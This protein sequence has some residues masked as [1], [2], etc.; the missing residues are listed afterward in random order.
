[1]SRSMTR[2]RRDLLL[3]AGLLGL[4]MLPLRSAFGATTP[5]PITFT[6]FRNGSLFGSHNLTFTNDGPRLIVDIEIAFDYKLAFIPLY[7]YRHQNREVWQDGRLIALSSETDDNG[8]AHKVS[9]TAE[10]DQLIV[11]GSDGRL[12]LP[13]DTPSTSYWNEA[14]I[15]RGEWL[16]TQRG[17]L[18]RSKVTPGKPEPLTIGDKNIEAR[19][20]QL[21]GDITCTLWYRDGVW[22]KLRFIASDDS[23]ID[24]ALEPS[25]SG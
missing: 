1:M 10:R 16:D 7:R 19:P 25:G 12:T 13:A 2:S 9:V 14:T 17:K 23:V 20:Y 24:Y 6:A 5:S 3:H 21:D 11:D 22:V 15:E 18:V 4:S 8:T